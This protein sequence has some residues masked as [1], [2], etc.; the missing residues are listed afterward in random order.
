MQQQQRQQQQ[1]QQRT[2]FTTTDLDRREASVTQREIIVRANE[3][4]VAAFLAEKISFMGIPQ[5][6]E[7]TLNDSDSQ[8]PEDLQSVLLADQRARQ[9]ATEIIGEKQ[10]VN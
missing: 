4:A 7:R 1:Q 5:V 6:I 8:V 3:V 10:W 2:P 9:L